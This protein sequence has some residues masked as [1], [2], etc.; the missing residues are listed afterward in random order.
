M[1][2]QNKSEATK[3]LLKAKAS[4]VLDYPFFG[5]LVLRLRYKE[6]TNVPSAGVDGRT[7]Y[8]NPNFIDQLSLLQTT[9]LLAHEVMHVALGHH[10]RRY[11]RDHKRWNYACDYA[12][13]PIIESAK[14]HGKTLQLP[15][16]NFMGAE[17]G[18]HIEEKFKNMSADHIYSLLPEVPPMFNLGCGA[19]FD[20]PELSDGTN[21]SPDDDSKG[22]KLTK[23]EYDMK[24]RHEE[25]EWK[26][27]ALQ[28]AQA[29]KA[30]GKLPASIEELITEINKPKINWIAVLRTFMIEIRRDDYIWSRPN[31][32]HICNGIY[33]PMLFS[34]GMGEVILVVDTSGSITKAELK[35]FAGELNSIL[36]DVKPSKVHVIYCDAAIQGAPKEILP[37]D[38][39]VP[40]EKKGGGGTDFTEPFEWTE[41]NVSNPACLVYLTDLY[42]PCNAPKPAYPVL[43]VCT[44]GETEVPFGQVLPL[45]IE[46]A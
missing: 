2:I 39:P 36:G 37:E 43:W 29:A 12:I 8:Y 3:K 13:D 44:S 9:G 32:R 21:N 1:N 33:L 4:L 42:G 27:A 6:T 26:I 23:E 11:D 40:L 46:A 41:Q 38:F 35:Q 28:A 7:C 22:Q 14:H 5:L 16:L 34:E 15:E 24:A 10:V 31:R 20:S 17:Y 30:V 25:T 19:V 45:D 18:P